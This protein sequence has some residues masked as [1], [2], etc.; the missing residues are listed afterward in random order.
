MYISY[1]TSIVVNTDGM[2]I[3]MERRSH[4]CVTNNEFFLNK[5]FRVFVFF[6]LFFKFIERIT[7]N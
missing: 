6:F 5:R 1:R 4:D 2:V 7:W 3:R